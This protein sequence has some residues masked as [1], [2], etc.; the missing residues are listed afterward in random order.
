MT[1]Y[2]K[3]ER[4]TRKWWFYLLLFIVPTILPPFAGTGLGYWRELGSFTWYV[5]D[6]VYA[7]KLTHGAS[8]PVMH[9]LV[10]LLILA[11]LIFGR[12]F[13]RAFSFLV[14]LNFAYVTFI[15]TSVITERYG[16]VVISELFAWYL[17][18]FLL[19]LWEGFSPKNDYAWDKSIRTPWWAIPLAVIAFW[20]PDIAWQP[21]LGFFIHSYSPTAFCMMTPIYLTVL[22]FIHPRVNVL[23]LRVQGFTGVIIGVITLVVAFMKEPS[24]GLYWTLLHVPLIA[25]SLYSFILGIRANPSAR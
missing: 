3:L 20:D 21:H 16:L 11:L 17:V 23:L 6:M 18:V 15:Q 10:V 7:K 8:M 14:A 2:Q 19:W 5:S 4:L 12:R 22:L 9:L 1:L 24:D 25:I 13:G